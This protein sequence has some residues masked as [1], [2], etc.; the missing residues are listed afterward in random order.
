MV[1]DGV[2]GFSL[3]L[4]QKADAPEVDAEHRDLGVARQFGC[5]QKGSVAAE[6][7]HQFAALGG[8][9]VGVDHLDVDTQ[10]LHVA[11]VQVH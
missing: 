1:E 10:G 2:D 5:P 9:F 6:H 3:G 4:G 11:G 7:Q 8:A